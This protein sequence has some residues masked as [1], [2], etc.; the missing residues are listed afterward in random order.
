[1]KKLR[2]LG[3]IHAQAAIHGPELLSQFQTSA[4]VIATAMQT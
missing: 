2:A 1:M 4:Q 3:Q